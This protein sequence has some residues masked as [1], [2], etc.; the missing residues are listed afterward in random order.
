MAENHG[1]AKEEI[2]CINKIVFFSLFIIQFSIV[3]HSH[4]FLIY[5]SEI[6]VGFP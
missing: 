3:N 6:G 2:A 4:V 5:L 1:R